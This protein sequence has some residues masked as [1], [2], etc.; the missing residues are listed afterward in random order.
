VSSRH[1]IQFAKE[2]YKVYKRIRVYLSEEEGLIPVAWTLFQE[3]FT[4]KLRHFEARMKECYRQQ[5]L[6]VTS[7]EVSKLYKEAEIKWAKKLEKNEKSLVSKKNKK[8]KEPKSLEQTEKENVSVCSS[9]ND[10]GSSDEDEESP[11]SSQEAAN[12]ATKQ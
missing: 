10:D 5:R 9:E 1:Q 7:D 3:H 2:I 6:S 11:S 4:N 8:Q 12:S